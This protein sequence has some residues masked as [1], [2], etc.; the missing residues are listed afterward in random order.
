MFFSSS[1]FA[2]EIVT[3]DCLKEQVYV[4]LEG[5]TSKA[6]GS[7]SYQSFLSDEEYMSKT[8]IGGKEAY[9]C[10]TEFSEYTLGANCFMEMEFEDKQFIFW[11]KYEID[12][13]NGNFTNRLEEG[14]IGERPELVAI[15]SG[16]CK[17]TSKLF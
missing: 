8:E 3:L 4:V 6:N 10:F 11:S 2:D 5:K 7:F 15:Y 12:R 17:K 9:F 13:L 1:I 16:K 14:L